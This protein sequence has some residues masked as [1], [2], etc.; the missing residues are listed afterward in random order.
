MRRLTSSRAWAYGLFWSWNIIFLT[1]MFLG[2]APELLPEMLT[3]VQAGTIP[4]AF[5]VYGAILV[6][7]PA[8]AVAIGALWL[9]RAP[10]RLF[11]L[12]YGVEGPLMLML[13]LRFFVVREVTP[14]VALLMSVAGLGIATLLWQLLDRSIDQRGT[15]LTCLRVIGLTC[16]LLAG[17][18][19]S[20]WI[21]FYAVPAAD[22]IVRMVAEIPQALRNVSTWEWRQVPLWV[23]GFTLLAYTMTLFVLLPVAVPILYARSWWR[24][25]RALAAR[26]QILAAVAPATV[27]V[28][29]AALFVLTSRQPQHQAFALLKT[30]PSSPGEAAALLRQQETIR[31]GLLN[32]YLAPQ[33]YLSAQGEVR[34]VSEMY[35]TLGLTD[36]G[37][38][39]V[40]QLYEGVARPV[41]YEPVEPISLEE[42][43]IWENQAQREESG[44]AAELY[45]QFFDVPI[46]DGEHDAVVLAARSTWSVGQAETA[47]QAVDDREI[48]LTHQELVVAE[49]G[50]WA[51][52]E[53]YEV[54]QNQT[55]DRQEVVYY[56]S[57]PESAVITGVW[58]GNGPDRDRRFAYR[59]APRGAAQS[60]YR[61]EVRR[62]R[63][64]ALVEQIG[65]RQYRLRVFPI[66]PRQWRWDAD[67]E[68]ST[69]E[70]APQ[71]HMWLT[72]R[73]LAEEGQ[74]P[75]PRLAEKRNVYWDGAS[76]RLANGA[77]MQADQET[78][79]P[80]ALPAA[81]APA[82]VAHRIDFPSGETIV[83]RPATAG[84][85]PPPAENLRLAVVLDRSRSM[86]RHSDQIKAALARLREIPHGSAPT[87][88]YL[89]ASA[90]RGEQP[91]VVDLDRLDPD[92][93]VYY[94]GQNPGQLLAQFA[95]L[96]ADR[97]YDA[98]VVLTDDSGYEL[99]PG[100]LALSTPGAPVWMVHLGGFPLGYDDPTLAAIQASGGGVASTV[101]EALTRLAIARAAGQGGP[102]QA[103]SS[104]II[105]GYVWLTVPTSA[106]APIAG[107]QVITH[108]PGDDFA[109]FAARRL[110]L[111]AMQRQRAMLDDPEVL[112][113]LHA[114]AIE[115]SIVTPFSSMIVLVNAE[116]QRRL[117]ALER[118]DDRFQREREEVGETTPELPTVTGVPEPEEWLLIGLAALML[119]WY[120]RSSRAK[121]QRRQPVP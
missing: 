88:V 42:G 6:A 59:V 84:D 50:D 104:D 94:G 115:H 30:P 82:P 86:A 38:D 13:A 12:G 7:I 63:D 76:T 62:N 47:W 107:G 15:L 34:H 25:V 114:T 14:G 35:R 64:P 45:E 56:F 119:L 81:S 31:A 108:A 96:H 67:S 22:A 48:L 54:Y 52:M 65:P 36:Q 117:D 1:F 8:L 101:D 21:A 46:D 16:L 103:P 51:D 85:R 69:V 18:Y 93:L 5:L 39:R 113:R 28:I 32:A 58:L 55:A 33:R 20:V 91:A 11:T 99:G 57:L 72:W 105:D 95:A 49:H 66:E 24:G 120:V 10:E 40:Q 98:I 80:A 61:N 109:A 37:A 118:Q 77:P 43:Q 73:V 97:Q 60:L 9:R 111:A 53:L 87:D 121:A 71:L 100:D 23:L 3:A 70:E 112:D 79:L 110:I 90:Y 74:W 89:T 68:R 27:L 2:F 78:W 41:L 19:A 106:A 17:L 75:L 44:R 4:A 92:S 116:Q 29:C 26:R 102:A 83:A